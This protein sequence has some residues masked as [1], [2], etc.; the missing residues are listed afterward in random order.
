M[1]T[2][3]GHIS[4][5]VAFY[6][7][8]IVFC[9]QL[10]KEY[11]TKNRRKKETC[12]KSDRSKTSWGKVLERIMD[13]PL[14]SF[15]KIL[16]GFGAA[17]AELFYPPGTNKL[18]LVDA[19]GHWAHLNEWQHFTMYMSFAASGIIDIISQK[20][21][22]KRI[23]PLEKAAV[24]VAFYVTALLL[25]Y[26]RHGKEEIEQEVH[27]LLLYANLAMC[28]VLT[29][30]MWRPSDKILEYSHTLLVMQMGSWL[31]H[32]AFILFPRN[33]AAKWNDKDMWNQMV[34]PIF[35][36]WHIFLNV[37]VLGIIFLIQYLRLKV[38]LESFSHPY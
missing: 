24:A 13:F 8:G 10:S 35:F 36:C 19:N 15:L 11:L 6:S 20:I 28:A 18:Y 25:F 1:G 7:F 4:P 26:H 38:S 37:G 12:K 22:R 3:E 16:Y 2:W 5:G 34:L 27:E 14:D 31:F 23:V 33:G 29:V 30:E 32:A 17:M 21:M 9:F